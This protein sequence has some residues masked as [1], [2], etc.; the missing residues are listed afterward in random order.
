MS[1]D[2]LKNFNWIDILLAVIFARIIFIGFK[3]GVVVEFFKLFAAAFAVFI[4]LHYFSSL[5][6]VFQ[7]IVHLPQGFAD[8]ISFGLLWIIVTLIFKFIRDGF[9]ILLKIEAHSTFERWGALIFSLLRAV[10]IGSLTI[11]FLRVFNI[12][13]FNANLEQSLLSKRLAKISPQLYEKSLNGFIS[14]F[15]PTEE[16]NADAMKLQ[17][18]DAKDKK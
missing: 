18:F 1:A 2:F 5:S 16:L 7:N 17:E 13:Y 14:K 12:E 8:F 9:L 6:R 3:R 4:N 11:L 15:F 10:L